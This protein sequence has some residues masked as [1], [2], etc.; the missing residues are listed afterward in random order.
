[1]FIM[2]K[3]TWEINE[4]EEPVYAVCEKRIKH[5]YLIERS[6]LPF[7][8]VLY[9]PQTKKGKLYSFFSGAMTDSEGNRKSITKRDINVA[10]K[11]TINWAKDH[12]AIA[13]N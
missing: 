9:D 3:R 6:R 2:Y 7:L 11:E 8:K 4:P 10:V 5:Q 1:M 12:F 13:E